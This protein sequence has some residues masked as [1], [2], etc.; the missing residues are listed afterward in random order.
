MAYDRAQSLALAR[1]TVH[2]TLGIPALYTDPTGFVRKTVRVRWHS[3][4]ALQGNII[5]AGY[6]EFLEGV[7]RVIFNAVELR[8]QNI[9]LKKNGTLTI[10]P[11]GLEKD[12]VLTLDT[13]E[14]SEGPENIIWG[15]T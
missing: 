1:K 7:K 8:E 4:L 12:V 3:R 14:P 11:I 5:D 10:R 15:V 13:L 6:T 9:T 2:K